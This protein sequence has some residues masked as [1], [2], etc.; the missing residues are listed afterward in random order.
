MI[1]AALKVIPWRYVLPGVGAALALWAAYDWHG[2]K[3]DAVKIAAMQE[4]A[5]LDAADFEAA[6]REA[7]AMQQREI[8][9][10]KAGSSTAN[11]ETIDALQ[12]RNNRL[13]A[14]YADLRRLWREAA[15]Q[16][17]ASGPGNSG[18][19]AIPGNAGGD[20]FSAARAAG[21]VDFETAATLAEAADRN[22]AGWEGVIDW[23]LRQCKAWRGPKPDECM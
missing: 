3:I 1:P 8:A 14:A 16:A 6:R 12:A 23:Y 21:W 20:P 7:E 15:P 19:T 10:A 2:G 9:A 13:G 22:Q 11:K 17:A 4:Q 18:A 5:A